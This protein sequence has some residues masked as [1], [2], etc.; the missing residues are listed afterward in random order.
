MLP[1]LTSGGL[2]HWMDVNNGFFYPGVPKRT[3][4]KERA[5]A[6]IV[7]KTDMMEQQQNLPIQRPRPPCEMSE[8]GYGIFTAKYLSP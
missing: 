2:N 8:N 4:A 1:K 3:M 7:N 6:I 5:I